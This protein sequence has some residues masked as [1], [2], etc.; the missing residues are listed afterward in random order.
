MVPSAW[1]MFAIV[2]CISRKHCETGGVGVGVL[3]PVWYL[4]MGGPEVAEI[5]EAGWQGAS[6]NLRSDRCIIILTRAC[7]SFY[8]GAAAGVMLREGVFLVVSLHL[9]C[10]AC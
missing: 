8:Y 2:L 6:D 9:L 5:G 7:P 4:G 1:M 3:I 10:T